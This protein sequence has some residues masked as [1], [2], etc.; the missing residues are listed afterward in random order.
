MPGPANP[1]SKQKISVSA[2]GCVCVLMCLHLEMLLLVNHL[3]PSSSPLLLCHLPL[4]L[5]AE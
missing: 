2:S 4:L 1:H 5:Y 3:Q